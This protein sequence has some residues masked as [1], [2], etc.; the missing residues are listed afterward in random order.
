MIKPDPEMPDGAV[1]V[2]A[3]KRAQVI[4]GSPDRVLDQLVALREEIGHFGTLLM[5]GHDWDQPALWR[6]SM[7]LLA[8]AV[9][10]RFRQHA[11]ATFKL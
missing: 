6:R 11:A 4:A 5:T 9:M 10:P 3:I 2:D 1:T 7:T 8:T